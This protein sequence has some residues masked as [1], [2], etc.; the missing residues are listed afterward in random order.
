MRFKVIIHSNQVSEPAIT[1][2]SAQSNQLSKDQQCS[3]RADAAL[4]HDSFTNLDFT[5]NL[6][7]SWEISNRLLKLS[8]KLEIF[9][10]LMLNKPLHLLCTDWLADNKATSIPNYQSTLSSEFPQEHDQRSSLSLHSSWNSWTNST[11]TSEPGWSVG[12]AACSPWAQLLCR[13]CWWD[14]GNPPVK[15]N[16]TPQPTYT[17]VSSGY[18]LTRL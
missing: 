2:S 13:T 4:S 14:W 15:V 12:P 11:P 9:Y 3:Q 5:S 6:R 1:Y 10:F 16:G 17:L 7:I 8:E 18:C